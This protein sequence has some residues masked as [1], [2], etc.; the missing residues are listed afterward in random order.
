MEP[1]STIC[2]PLSPN[3]QLYSP[4]EP[5]RGWGGFNL[6]PET[7]RAGDGLSG[8][9]DLRGQSILK[10]GLAQLERDCLIKMQGLML[11]LVCVCVC[12]VWERPPT[13]EPTVAGI[14][15]H[16]CYGSWT[17]QWSR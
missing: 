11:P 2:C 10:W 4:H 7:V 17:E 13:S 15:R 6:R 9:S 14:C 3:K 5:Q 16:V 1:D 12:E 8:G